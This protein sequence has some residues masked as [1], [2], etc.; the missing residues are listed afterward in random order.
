MGAT[1]GLWI[2]SLING[3]GAEHAD[4]IVLYRA[5]AFATMFVSIFLSSAERPETILTYD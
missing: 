5:T 4:H 1:V 3:V 2:D